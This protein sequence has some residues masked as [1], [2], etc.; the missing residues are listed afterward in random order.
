MFDDTNIRSV[1]SILKTPCTFGICSLTD[2]TSSYRDEDEEHTRINCRIY[3]LTMNINLQG[4]TLLTLF[5]ISRVTTKYGRFLC[6]YVCIGTYVP[7]CHW[8][9]YSIRRYFIRKTWHLFCSFDRFYYQK[10]V[11]KKSMDKY[12]QMNF[13]R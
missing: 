6:T 4:G 5:S 8:A 11:L 1:L 12:E 9:G 3:S 13:V 7:I 10:R 2:R